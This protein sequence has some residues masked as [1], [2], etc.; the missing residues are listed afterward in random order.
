MAVSAPK[1]MVTASSSG[2]VKQKEIPGTGAVPVSQVKGLYLTAYNFISA[3]L[4]TTVLGRT[5]IVAGLRGPAFVPIVVDDFLRCTQTIALLEVVHSVLG[6]G[7]PATM[8]PISMTI[9]DSLAGIVRAPLFTT[10]MQVASRLLLVWA[11]VYPFP[12][13]TTSSPFYT[14]MVLA[15]S[16]T[17]VI[18]YSYF[19]LSLARGPERPPPSWFTALRYS[20]FLVLYP[21]GISSEVRLVY[22][23]ATTPSAAATLHPL[24]PAALYAVLAVY[25]PGSY[26]LY[27]HMLAQRRKVLR[28][29]KAEAAVGKKVQ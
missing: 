13:E 21:V 12:A 20:T 26:I 28:R 27:T 17:E 3:I 29:L 25:V 11:I 4:W 10:A 2:P 18:R 23:A 22:L 8:M 6:M 14:S 15:W 19:A 16:L 5:A 24:Y 9:A 7:A 1:K